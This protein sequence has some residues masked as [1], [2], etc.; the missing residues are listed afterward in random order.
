MS[1]ALLV[2]ALSALKFAESYVVYRAHSNTA[3]RVAD[4]IHEIET[5]LSKECG[6]STSRAQGIKDW[7]QTFE[8]DKDK[9][10]HSLHR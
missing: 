9:D 5:E 7:E 1:R 3:K 8:V 10:G 2:Q 6:C 4:A